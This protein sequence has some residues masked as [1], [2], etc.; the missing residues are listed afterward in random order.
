MNE[1]DPPRMIIR[2]HNNVEVPDDLAIVL[3][4]SDPPRWW[5]L[6][7]ENG[8]VTLSA[9]GRNVR[10]PM[11]VVEQNSDT[12]TA[13][14]RVTF[15]ARRPDSSTTPG[16]SPGTA[17]AAVS[18]LEIMY[19]ASVAAAELSPYRPPNDLVRPTARA[20]RRRPDA[21]CPLH[22]VERRR[23]ET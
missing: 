20:R 6:V 23:H 4:K 12:V 14:G 7:E 13:L 2:F 15:S 16:Y 9:D 8:D 10:S 21:S 3:E 17:W 18:H 22:S 11:R 5:R 1:F 19:L